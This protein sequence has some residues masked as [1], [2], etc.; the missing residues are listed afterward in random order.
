MKLSAHLTPRTGDSIACDA[1]RPQLPAK[2]CQAY[3]WFLM[4]VI[5]SFSRNISAKKSEGGGVALWH[6][7]TGFQETHSRAFTSIYHKLKSNRDN[8]KI[9]ESSFSK[10]D[11]KILR[12]LSVP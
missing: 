3:Q 5:F 6:A 2:V 12:D 10:T 4:Q 7:G 8:E 9:E 11:P 1:Q